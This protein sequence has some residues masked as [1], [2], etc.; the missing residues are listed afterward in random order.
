[1]VAAIACPQIGAERTVTY[2]VRRRDMV[3]WLMPGVGEFAR[4][5]GG[6]GYRPAGRRM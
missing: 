5:P 3:R 6:D 4:K 2:Q 1:M